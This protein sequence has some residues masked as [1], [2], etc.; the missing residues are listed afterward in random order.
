MHPSRRDLLRATGAGAATLALPG[1]ARAALPQGLVRIL[2]GFPPGGGT[3]VMGRVIAETLR[4]RGNLKNVVIENRAGASGTLAC[5]ALKHAAP[6]GTTLLF[7]PSASTVQ[8]VLTFRRLPWD[9]RTDFAPVTM[10]GTVQTCWVLAPH[11]PARTFEDYIAWVKADGRR[12]SFGSTALG[13][14]THF[15]GLQIAAAFGVELEPVGYRGAAPL[16]SDLAAGHIVAGCG[17]VSDFLTHHKDG[18]LRIVLTSGPKR[19]VTTPEVPT[20]ADLGHPDQASFGFY[21]FFAPAGTPAP[22][23]AALNAELAAATLEPE[24]KAQLLTIGLEPEV[25]TPEALGRIL[26]ED[27]ER[28]RPVVER[29]GFKVD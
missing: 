18:K 12:G 5:E 21:A 6:D 24:V 28:W 15:F 7:A 26:A 19:G 17:G 23:V 10:T 13:S 9:P 4:K 16:I 3:D 8:P 29:S 14:S 1:A 25:S 22:M 27:I 11:L 20:I 2:V